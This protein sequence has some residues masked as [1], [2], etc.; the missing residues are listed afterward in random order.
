MGFRPVHV[1]LHV[2][3]PEN[4]SNTV[5]VNLAAG[6]TLTVKGADG[7]GSFRSSSGRA[8]VNAYIGYEPDDPCPPLLSLGL[9]LQ[10]APNI[11]CSSPRVDCIKRSIRAFQGPQ[12]S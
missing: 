12:T 3:P 10:G 7:T 11:S 8:D 9:A 5:V 1:G 4:D 2:A 6:Q